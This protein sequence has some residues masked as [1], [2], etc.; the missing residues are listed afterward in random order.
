MEQEH[1]QWQN[2][3]NKITQMVCWL[4]GPFSSKR[5]NVCYGLFEPRIPLRPIRESKLFFHYKV[6]CWTAQFHC[7]WGFPT[8]VA[9]LMNDSLPE[10]DHTGTSDNTG[11]S[12]YPRWSQAG[13]RHFAIT[14]FTGLHQIK[15]QLSLAFTCAG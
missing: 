14:I 12:V 6:K 11:S 4:S 8:F 3:R 1:K 2:I 5:I 10:S 13:V 15:M 7:L 9:D